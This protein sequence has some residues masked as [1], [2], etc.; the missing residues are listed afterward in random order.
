MIAVEVGA[1]GPAGIP[2]LPVRLWNVK[3]CPHGRRKD[4]CR[5]CGGGSFC[6]HDRRK[7]HCVA[8]TGCMQGKLKEDAPRVLAGNAVHIIG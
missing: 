1:P 6:I 4:R 2:P 7:Y 5:D 8:C 3:N